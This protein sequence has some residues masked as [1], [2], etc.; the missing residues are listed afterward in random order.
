MV[1]AA[2]E[3]GT[4]VSTSTS[5]S[6]AA[7]ASRPTTPDGATLQLRARSTRT[8]SPDERIV[9]TYEMYR[10]EDRISVSVT[11]VEL[12]RGRRRHA[13]IYTEQGVYLDGHDTPA[14]ARARHAR[15]ARA[16]STQALAA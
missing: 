10:D 8:S 9:Y 11:T 15:A 6:A 4:D 2:L 3:R 5:A 14:A 7:S 16:G 12:R 13:L 1:R